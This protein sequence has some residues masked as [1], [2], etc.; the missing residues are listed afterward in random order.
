M[1]IETA[2]DV[3]L[4]QQEVIETYRQEYEK[5]VVQKAKEEFYALTQKQRDRYV[6]DYYRVQSD[7]GFFDWLPCI[8]FEPGEFDFVTWAKA[9]KEAYLE[10]SPKFSRNNQVGYIFKSAPS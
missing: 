4:L 8:F 10:A 3:E 7:L 5:F 1:D 2:K 6:T 9:H